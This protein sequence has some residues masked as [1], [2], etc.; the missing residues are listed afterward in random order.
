MILQYKRPS[1]AVL[2]LSELS[3]AACS[4]PGEISRLNVHVKWLATLLLPCEW[5]AFQYL[6]LKQNVYWPIAH[7]QSSQ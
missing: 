6:A 1:V 5:A 4:F 7:P 3:C 2:F